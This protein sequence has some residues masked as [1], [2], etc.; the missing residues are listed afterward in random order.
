MLAEIIRRKFHEPRQTLVELFSRLTFN[1]LTGNT[2]D[3]ARNHAA[4]W[5][6]RMLRLTPAY[7]IAPQRRGGLEANQAMVVANGARNAQLVLALAAAPA[8]L[9]DEATAREIIDGQAD[10][11]RDNWKA[12]SDEAR[13]SDT[14]RRYF[15]GRQIFN[16]YAFDG[17]GQKASLLD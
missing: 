13:M 5:D 9:I 7:D 6:G 17:Y 8:F 15:E 4:F 2:D 11:I 16:T 14:E 10:V 12:V 1:I 3:H